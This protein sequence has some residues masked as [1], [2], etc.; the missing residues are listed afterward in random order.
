VLGRPNKIFK[1]TRTGQYLATYLQTTIYDSQA[2]ATSSPWGGRDL[3]ADESTNRLY[4]GWEQ[5]R[6]AWHVFNPITGNLDAGTTTQ[7]TGLTN[8]IR[9]LAIRGDNGRFL[10]CDS[11]LPLRE[12]T[13][14]GGVQASYPNTFRSGG[15][16]SAI[17]G[18]AYASINGPRLW[19]WSQDGPTAHQEA[20]GIELNLSTSPPTRTG[21][22][23]LGASF[24]GGPVNTAG[25]ADIT[26]DAGRLALVTVHQALPD[27]L[28]LYDLDAP[29]AGGCPCACNFDISTGSGVCDIFDFLAFGNE[30]SANHPCACDMD[31][32]TGPGVCDIF[33]FLG[34][35]N[36]FNAGCP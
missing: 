21:R 11:M 7:I 29:C 16:P 14:A 12:F 8:T 2:T 31:V 6:L 15:G 30:F 36:G 10:S 32:S 1:F 33:D 35:G 22:E 23:F 24:G 26:C 20:F 34:F 3:A 17:A 4:Y 5:G 27:S 9:G 13:I 19:L 18:L 28:V 25:G